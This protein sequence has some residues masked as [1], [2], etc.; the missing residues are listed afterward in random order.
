MAQR[1]MFSLKIV[2]SDAFLNMP[3]ASRE[4][5]FQIGMR[6][7]DDGFVANI[8]SIARLSGSKAKNINDLIVNGFI[9]PFADN[10]VVIKH[11][12]MNNAIQKDRYVQTQYIEDY[13]SLFIK[14][15][16]AYTLDA[17][18]GSALNRECNPLV[19]DENGEISKSMIRKY[20]NHRD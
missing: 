15:N 17:E 10:V 3:I 7:D 18:Q 1:R 11:W 16:G 13:N 4:L 9:I 14:R 2:N 5:Y 20:R 8:K 6:A 12:K 19:A